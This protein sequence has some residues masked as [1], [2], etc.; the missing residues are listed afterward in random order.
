MYRCGVCR[1]CS[2]PHQTM[3]KHTIYR[4]GGRWGPLEGSIARE[5]P[6]CSECA[7]LLKTGTP[8]ASL[9]RERGIDKPAPIPSLAP[10]LPVAVVGRREAMRPSR[11]ISG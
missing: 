6:L 5:V 9:L 1:A 10:G 8:F 2:E 7:T 4:E 3:V 11:V